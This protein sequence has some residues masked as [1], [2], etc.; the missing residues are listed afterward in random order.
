VNNKEA[1]ARIKINRLLEEAGWSFFDGKGRK[2]NI[3]LEK[4]IKIREQDLDNLGE[5][6]ENC[7]NGYV[8]YLLLDSSGFPLIVLEAK[9]EEKDPLDGKE[10]ARR[11]AAN[12]GVRF[13][14]LSNGNIHYFWDLKKGNPNVITRFP[15]PESVFQLNRKKP[16]PDRKRN[17]IDN[18]D[19]TIIFSSRLIWIKL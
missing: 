6:F 15:T 7:R 5:D 11:Y 2:A 1:H 4:N 16:N 14:I 19:N 3:R 18:K 8:D 13:I 12:L 10:Q 9:C 17:N